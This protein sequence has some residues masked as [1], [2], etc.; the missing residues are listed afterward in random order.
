M[1]GCPG[2]AGW[3]GGCQR[4]LS[5]G[6]G[7]GSTHCPS[8]A[9]CLSLSGF[10]EPSGST[11]EHSV[12]EYPTE[13]WPRG[14]PCETISTAFVLSGESLEGLAWALKT[15]SSKARNRE[16]NGSS[17]RVSMGGHEREL[18][19]HTCVV[20]PGTCSALVQTAAS[21][22]AGEAAACSLYHS[23]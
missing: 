21:K 22:S 12:S 1:S 18:R 8:Q 11:V 20:R 3:N 6:R 9:D 13:T 10:Q 2:P 4:G 16:E 5:S 14:D 23:L 15:C 17:L 19:L 7:F